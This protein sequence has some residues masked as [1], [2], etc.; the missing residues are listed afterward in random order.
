MN[1]RCTCSRLVRTSPGSSVSVEADTA[2]DSTRTVDIV[3]IG[4]R[5]RRSKSDIVAAEEP[6]D[7]RLNGS[8]F[9][10]TM[11]TPGADQRAGCRL[12]PV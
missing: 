11:R 12:S 3:H 2:L 1:P 9:V 4:P 6:L 10:I 5:G 7:I 8:P